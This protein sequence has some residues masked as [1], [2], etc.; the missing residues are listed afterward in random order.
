MNLHNSRPTHR[1][2]GLLV[3]AAL[4]VGAF[5]CAGAL[6]AAA[7]G[8]TALTPPS[9]SGAAREGAT[10]TA[11]PGVWN[12]T[13][14]V[15]FHYAW[16]KCNADGGSCTALSGATHD[17]F[18]VPSGLSG[19]TLRVAV[20]ATDSSGSATSRSAVSGVVAAAGGEPA[21]SALPDVSGTAQDGK[22]LHATAGTW[23]GDQPMSFVY[24][25]QRCSAAGDACAPVSG[26]SSKDYTVTSADAGSTLRVAVTATNGA[27]SNAAY[28]P[29]SSLIASA[30]A[31][32]LSAAP[33]VTGTAKEGKTLT[34]SHGDWSGSTPIAFT[35]AWWRCDSAGSACRQISGANASTYTPV[36]ADTGDVLRASVK[37]ANSAGSATAVTE[38]TD[39]VAAGTRDAPANTKAPKI[40]GSAR[41]GRK[42]TVSNGTWS[43]ATPI[44]FTYTWQ[45][46]DS[47][48][49]SCNSISGATSSTYRPTIGDVGRKLRAVVVAKNAS[50]SAG[51]S[52]STV[53]VG[54]PAVPYNVALPVIYASSTSF[55]AGQVVSATSGSW[56]GAGKVYYDFSWNRCRNGKFSSCRP[57]AGAHRQT[58]TVTKHD[59][60]RRLMVLVRAHNGAGVAYA[61][62]Q[63]TPSGVSTALHMVTGPSISGTAAVGSTVTAD[64]GT[65]TA[66]NGVSYTYQW[67]RCAPSCA[68]IAG[69]KAKTYTL[70]QDDAG[71]DLFVQIKVMSGGKSVFVDSNHVRAGS[72]AAA[73]GALQVSSV[74]LPDRLV[75]SGV[76]FRPGAITSLAPITARFR[77]TEQTGGR[78][79]RG[80]LVYA[81]GIPYSWVQGGREVATDANGWA[82]V[83]IAPSGRLQLRQGK[84]LVLFVRARKPGDNLLA[85]VSTRRLVQVS[86]RPRTLQSVQASTAPYRSTGTPIGSVA[87]PNRLVISGVQFAPR[88]LASRAPFTA[89][90][91]VTDTSGKPVAGA[92]V[93]ALGLPYSWVQGGHEVVTDANGWATV[94]IVPSG[95]LPLRHGSAL[96]MFVR[97]RKPGD[98]LLGGVSTRRLVQVTVR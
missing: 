8:P 55:H 43:G 28:S 19:S 2:R 66:G 70:T 39:P 54:S 62:S 93:Y 71:H 34:V 49:S 52:S 3:A 74:A 82:T 11:A 45:T 88:R 50:G 73:T 75:I 5:A 40:S 57:I 76:Q 56:V 98:N 91:R 30:S 94:T 27:G 35:Y 48:G 92:L 89:R 97:A 44:T 1:A 4:L 96:V 36:S 47:K 18:R 37:A 60:H 81:L 65:W 64:P 23:T 26:A 77:V 80:A 67:T 31:P 85:G 59:V 7:S 58:Y 32:A 78:P 90:F 6:G 33:A 83:T 68:P 51:A 14:P 53:T 46:C 9:L 79:V 87:L 15:T 84:E 20:T 10:L 63:I 22:T 86:I 16:E 12:A 72:A 41:V 17:D 69:A 61:D 29:P 25:W 13:A 42:L 95:A 38:A 21:A 24:H